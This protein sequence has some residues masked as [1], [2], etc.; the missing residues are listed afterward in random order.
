MIKATA[1][2]EKGAIEEAK[3][4]TKH[5]HRPRMTEDAALVQ[6]LLTLQFG[7]S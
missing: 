1:K 5:A 2:A 4:P 7:T 3:G 6:Y